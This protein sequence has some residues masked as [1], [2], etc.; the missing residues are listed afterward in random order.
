M[1]LWVFLQLRSPLMPARASEAK[2]L[3]W[4]NCIE[5]QRHSDLS[6]EKWCL[7]NQIR[8]HTFYYWRDKLFPKQLQ[9][10]SFTQL[11]MKRFDEIFLSGRGIH[12]R[13]GSDCNPDLRKQLFAIFAERSC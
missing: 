8:P 9:K 2:Q 10:S 4:K 13:I 11:K 7:Q 6:I 12:I 1:A 3:E 5:R